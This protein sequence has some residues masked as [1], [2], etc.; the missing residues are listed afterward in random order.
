M[1]RLTIALVVASGTLAACSEQPAAE[2][3]VA[4]TNTAVEMGAMSVKASS[5][6]T[7]TAID[8]AAGKI[9]LDHAPIAEA[10]WPAMTMGFEA[11]PD[12]IDGIGVGD[13]VEFEMAMSGGVSKV[14]SI[15]A[16]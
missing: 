13:N 2:P 1:M 10:N 16:R 14:T 15:R 9:T 3:P 11:E 4:A 7:V 5:T 12:V 6:G 8:H